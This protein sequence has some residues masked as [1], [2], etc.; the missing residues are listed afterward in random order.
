MFNNINLT[1]YLEMAK[2]IYAG[3]PQFYVAV[4]CII[5][6]Y[7]NNDIQVLLQKR[8]IEPFIGEQTLL[9][10]FVGADESLDDA[11]HR[12]LLERTGMKNVFLEQVETFGEIDRDPGGRVISTAYYALLNK[13]LHNTKLIQKYGCQWVSLK[14]LPHLHFDHGKMLVKALQLLR[15]RIGYTPVAMNLLPSEF[16]LTQL[17]HVYEGILGI[18]LDKRN[19]RKRLKEMPYFAETGK[20]DKSFS[21]RAASLYSFDWE[22][23]RQLKY[24]HL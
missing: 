16:T 1:S 19:F 18:E 11:A 17:Q 6:A 2:G 3:N 20:K 21:K 12:V 22:M 23:Y 10:G 15:D 8:K 14:E 4:D 13:K 7:E 24:Y 5:F 9:G